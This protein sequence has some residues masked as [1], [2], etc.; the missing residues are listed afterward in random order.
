MLKAFL[1]FNF[2][3]FFFFVLYLAKLQNISH[4]RDEDVIFLA[5]KA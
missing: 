5:Q 3:F 4:K 2:Y 1:L